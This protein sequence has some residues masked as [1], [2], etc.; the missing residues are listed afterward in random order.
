MLQEVENMII[1]LSKIVVNPDQPR[2][3]FDQDELQSLADS[4]KEHGLINPIAVEQAGDLFILI[5]GERRWRACKLAGLKE[6]EASVRPSKN[7]AG[8]E[9]RLLLAMIAN[10]QRADLNPMEEARAYRKM[11]D[12]GMTKSQIGAAV[13]VSAATV[14]ARISLLTFA[15]EIQALWEA[16]QLSSVPQVIAALRRIP[17]DD[18]RIR[19]AQGFA[20]RGTSL[21][22]IAIVCGRI[23][24]YVA[25]TNK[26]LVDQNDPPALQLATKQA[27]NRGNI[28]HWNAFTQA[29][30]TPPWAKITEA[31]K[32][33]CENCALADMASEGTCKDCPLVDLLKYLMEERHD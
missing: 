15:P 11:S 6:I 4:I 2:K 5:D 33:T 10:L 8:G 14:F 32:Y 1:P 28:G 17:D 23:A 16:G 25:Q 29:R 3:T 27:K 18:T 21:A 20:R 19:L 22:F 31:V 12:L 9:E 7:G 26:P 24:R 13:A 30:L